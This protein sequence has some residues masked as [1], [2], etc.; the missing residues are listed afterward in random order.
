MVWLLLYVTD[1]ISAYGTESE[2]KRKRG[3]T[4]RE[5]GGMR[6]GTTSADKER[7]KNQREGREERAVTVVLSH[8]AA[9]H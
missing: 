3:R 2:R 6:R 4:Q 9:L 1:P 7:E 5:R 8:S